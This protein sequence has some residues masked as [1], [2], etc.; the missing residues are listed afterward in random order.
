M[1]IGVSVRCR[2]AKP[3]TV[4]GQLRDTPS[5]LAARA[6]DDVK[7]ILCLD[8]DGRGFG[9]IASRD[10]VVGAL[11]R[12]YPGLRPVLFYTPYVAAAWAIIGQG[13]A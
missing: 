11:Q 9:A 5:D 12:R 4:T 2:Y 8:I 7:R 6:R 10:P 1:R 13:S 3:Q